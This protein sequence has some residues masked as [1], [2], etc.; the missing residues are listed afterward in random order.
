[1]TYGDRAFE[2]VGAIRPYIKNDKLKGE[3]G[4]DGKSKEG[5]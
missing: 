4:A 1:M 5:R 3:A 2:T